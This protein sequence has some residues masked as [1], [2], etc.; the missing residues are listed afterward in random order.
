[1]HNALDLGW[2]TSEGVYAAKD[3]DTYDSVNPANNFP[4]AGWNICSRN[5]KEYGSFETVCIFDG[6]D[7]TDV[8]DTTGAV[9]DNFCD[10]GDTE[11]FCIDGLPY[12]TTELAY[13]GS[14]PGDFSGFGD[15]LTVDLFDDEWELR[16][17]FKNFAWEKDG[18]KVDIAF[19]SVRGQIC[20]DGNNCTTWDPCPAAHNCACQWNAADGMD[21]S[22][23]MR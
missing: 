10:T 7:V 6:S 17:A 11:Y 16:I 9:A 22:R 21:M 5:L 20:V 4:V 23:Q 15:K 18:S 8:V 13:A 1:M 14:Q 19:P 2:K 12:R 3:F